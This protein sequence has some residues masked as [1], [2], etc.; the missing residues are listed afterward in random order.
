MAA[1]HATEQ[2]GLPRFTS[3]ECAK[4]GKL[5]AW[6]AHV[7]VYMCTHVYI[8]SCRCAFS[9]GGLLLAGLCLGP[10]CGTG[11]PA[12]WAKMSGKTYLVQ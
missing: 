3:P 11:R 5:F 10:G 4:E 7:Y 2:V 8:G 9:G 1:A 6:C 12:S